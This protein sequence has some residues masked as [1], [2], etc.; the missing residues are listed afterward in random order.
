VHVIPNAVAPTGEPISAD[1][2]RKRIDLPPGPIIGWVGRLSA[3]KGP[4][5]AL[6]AFARLNRAD[7]RLVM[8]GAGPDEASLRQRAQL[9]GVGDR[10]LWRGALPDAGR[11][12]PAFDVFL[13]SSRTEGAPI[14]L[15][16]AMAAMV[17]IVATRVGGVPDTIDSSSGLLVESG[18][19]A[20]LA[21]A[22]AQ[23]LDESDRASERSQHAHARLNE[24][25]SEQRWLARYESVYRSVIKPIVS[26]R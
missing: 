19:V 24:R 5:I 11:L 1:D 16:E 7:A 15:L 20:G 9:L 14:V 17:P 4:D 12:F 26:T 25:F 6:H 18:D 13:L 22:L 21:A 2:A 23:T 8:I 10:V 3:E